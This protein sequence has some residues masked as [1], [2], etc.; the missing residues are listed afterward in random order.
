MSLAQ[1]PLGKADQPLTPTG[2]DELL[3]QLP[4]WEL[5]EEETEP[6]LQRQFR[7]ADFNQALAFVNRVGELADAADH[8]PRVVLGWGEVTLQWWTHSLHGLHRNDFIMA[9]RSAAAA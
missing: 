1:E 3:D 2:I 6:R 4:E 9:A 5:V 8:H 7:F